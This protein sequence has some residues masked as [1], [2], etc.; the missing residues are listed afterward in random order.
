MVVLR[1]SG[2]ESAIAFFQPRERFSRRNDWLIGMSRISSFGELIR[3]KQ[4]RDDQGGYEPCFCH[5][6]RV[7]EKLDWLSSWKVNID[8]R[9]HQ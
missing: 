4:G 3:Y 6:G 8:V 2:G 9:K 5:S 1:I 7:K